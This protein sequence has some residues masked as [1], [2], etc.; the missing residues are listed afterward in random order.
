M[1]FAELPTEVWMA[2]I[3]LVIVVVNRSFSLLQA[4]L[5]ERAAD[6]RAAQAA[7]K[8]IGKI[9]EVKVTTEQNSAIVAGKLKEAAVEVKRDLQ[10]A[11]EVQQKISDRK[12]EKIDHLATVVDTV[13]KQT[14]SREAAHLLET[15]NVYRELAQAVHTPE[16][17]AKVE[18]AKAAYDRHVENQDRADATK[19]T[20][21]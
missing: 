10:V 11:A 18:R 14:N 2:I 8:V 21:P 17:V 12:E 5:Q 7:Q 16:N 9:E 4:L 6:R 1:L 20:T 3:G 13:Q 19:K 15:L